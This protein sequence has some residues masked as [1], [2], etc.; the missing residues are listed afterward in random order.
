MDMKQIIAS[1][2]NQ[3]INGLIALLL[4]ALYALTAKTL[5]GLAL[6]AAIAFI[7]FVFVCFL[8][9]AKEFFHRLPTSIEIIKTFF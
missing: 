6:F 3:S 5:R 7:A 4:N 1:I 2:G 9:G 8:M